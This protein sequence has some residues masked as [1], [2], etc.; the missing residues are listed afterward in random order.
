M[1]RCGERVVLEWHKECGVC[2]DA[3]SVWCWSGTSCAVYVS[4]CGEHVVLEWHKECG[5]CV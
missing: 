3:E 1:C 4:S 2:L 5:V